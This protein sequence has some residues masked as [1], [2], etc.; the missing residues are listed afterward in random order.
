M[1]SGVWSACGKSEAHMKRSA[2]KRSAKTGITVRMVYVGFTVNSARPCNRV[3]PALR[4]AANESGWHERIESWLPRV[5]SG[6]ASTMCNG[7]ILPQGLLTFSPGQLCW[8]DRRSVCYRAG[9]VSK[10]G[11]RY[12]GDRRPPSLRTD[13]PSSVPGYGGLRVQMCT[14][15]GVRRSGDRAGDD[16]GTR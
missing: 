6:L 4:K 1:Y 7:S 16:E 13:R 9:R 14:A 8:P 11:R 15:V 10:T 5:D 12:R 2:P 3:G